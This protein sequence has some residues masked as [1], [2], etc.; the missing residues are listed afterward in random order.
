MT[1]LL[2]LAYDFP[3]YVSVGGLRP[4]SWFKYLH[5]YGVYPTVITRQWENKFGNSLDYISAGYSA[6]IDKEVTNHGTIIK[7]PFK[8]N[9]ANK[10]LIKY[11]ENRFTLVRKLISAYYEFF[12]YVLP[13]GSKKEIYFAADEFLKNNRV[14]CIIA[15]GDPFVLFKYASQLSDKY[16]T[17]WIADY[18]DPWVQDKSIKGKV[19]N[20]WFTFLERKILRN[21]RK[22]TTV[23]SFFQ[24]QIE[25]NVKSKEFEI[26]Y[27]GYDPEIIKVTSG[28]KQNNATLSIAFAGTIKNGDPIEDVLKVCDEIVAENTDSKIE[29]HFYGINREDDV[30]MM[31]AQ[32]YCLLEQYTHFYS[33]TENIELAQ[34]IAKHNVCLLFNYYSIVGTKIFDYLAVKR[35]IILCYEKA[36]EFD[37]RVIRT[38]EI[39]TSP[40]ADIIIETNSGITIK[41]SEH[42][43]HT[44]QELIKET[45][46]QGFVSCSSI[47]VEKYSRIRQVERLSE[48]VKGI[49]CNS[50]EEMVN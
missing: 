27:N 3:P 28:I 46:E 4:Y 13:I 31:L 20:P 39:T 33:R 1:K 22:I 5:L 25:K 36:E 23:Q 49:S 19:Y 43:K 38:E 37:T 18:R 50:T 47:N 34:A 9:L 41:D 44:I 2:I 10:I 42:L 24:K 12:Q 21:T 16:S 14:D 17:P 7:T 29:L 15:T 11:G 30:K 45:K 40:Q 35:K 8:P 32:K 6:S 48:I 26:L